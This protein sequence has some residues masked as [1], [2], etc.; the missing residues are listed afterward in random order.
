MNKISKPHIVDF[1][2]LSDQNKWFSP[3]IR[4]ASVR[5]KPELIADLRNRFLEVLEDSLIH[6]HPLGSNSCLPVI[7]YCLERR[8]FL[9]D[10]IPVNVP[11][12][13]RDRPGFSI[14][15]GE[16][17]LYFECPLPSPESPSIGTT[18]A[19]SSMSE[20]PNTDDL[21]AALERIQLP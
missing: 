4:Y 21:G 2:R 14:A 17:T 7:S 18:S 9:L 8:K 12:V 10:G 15:R 6:F 1:L 20:E 13:S 5:S 11:K 16:V 3:R 19:A